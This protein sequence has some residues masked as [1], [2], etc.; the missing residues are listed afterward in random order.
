MKD[1]FGSPLT[2]FC[3]PAERLK[4]RAEREPDEPTGATLLGQ[5]VYGGICLVTGILIGLAW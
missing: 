2:D 1:K 3:A 4:P 5:W